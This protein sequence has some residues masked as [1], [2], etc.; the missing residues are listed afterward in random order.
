MPDIAASIPTKSALILERRD[1]AALMGPQDYLA[2]VE[3]AFRGLMSENACVPIPMHIPAQDAAFHVKGARLAMDGA[4]YVAVKLNGN[5]PGNPSRRDCRRSRACSCCA[6]ATDGSVL[7]VMDSIEITLRRTAAAS[8]LA[9]RFL[10][11]RDA[12]SIAICGCG[13]QGRAQLAALAQVL[14]LK[15]ARAWDLDAERARA[16]AND[17]RASLKI[18]VTAVSD[19]GDATRS[20]DVIVTATTARTPFLSERARSG[21]APSW[22]RSAPTVRTKASSRLSSWP[23]P[24]SSSTSC[25]NAP[26]WATCIMR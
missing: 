20:S 26:R 9:A 6:T 19:V 22:R 17:M 7:A 5:V 3:A 2:A 24:R 11:R 14:P 10:A 13:E 18:D 12:D 16:F 15:Y 8:A 21:R 1:I 4:V 23:A 25:R